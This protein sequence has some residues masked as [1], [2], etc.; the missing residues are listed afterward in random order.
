[1]NEVKLEVFRGW[2][3]KSFTKGR[4]HRVYRSNSV[5]NRPTQLITTC[6]KEVI[7]NCD[8]SLYPINRCMK[9]EKSPTTETGQLLHNSMILPKERIPTKA[10]AIAELKRLSKSQTYLVRIYGIY[11]IEITASW[12]SDVS[13]DIKIEET[14]IHP[15][16]KHDILTTEQVQA[17]LRRFKSE[18][19]DLC[20]TSDELARRKKQ[21]DGFN[22]RLTKIESENYFCKLLK[23]AENNGNGKQ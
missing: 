21:H 22:S 6:K 1:M 7:A 14:V 2:Y 8:F 4:W 13:I 20:D 10:S 9:C 16:R 18:I 19:D 15:K 11:G 5:H 3:R 12:E 23:I 17:N